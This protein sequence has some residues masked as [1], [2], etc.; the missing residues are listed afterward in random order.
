MWVCR[1]SGFVIGK[2]KTDALVKFE[3]WSVAVVGGLALT[4]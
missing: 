4:G 3:V 1:L 2:L